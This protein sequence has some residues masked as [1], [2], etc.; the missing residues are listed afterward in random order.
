MKSKGETG[1]KRDEDNGAHAEEESPTAAHKSPRSTAEESIDYFE[2]ALAKEAM[3]L[4]GKEAMR[5]KHHQNAYEVGSESASQVESESES[6]SKRQRPKSSNGKSCRQNQSGKTEEAG[7][8]DDSSDDKY[9][10]DNDDDDGKSSSNGK[11][12]VPAGEITKTEG[13]VC[14]EYSGE[15]FY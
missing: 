4:D 7:S 1:Q 13:Q 5:Q 6:D 8:C 9:S 3:E 15:K 2:K 11:R 12:Q 14:C 10:V